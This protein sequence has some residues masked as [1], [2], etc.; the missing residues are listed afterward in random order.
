[1]RYQLIL[2]NCLNVCV[3][4][5][6]SNFCS[7]FQREGPVI[8]LLVDRMDEVIYLICHRFRNPQHFI[9]DAKQLRKAVAENK[10]HLANGLISIGTETSEALQQLDITNNDRQAFLTAVNYV[11]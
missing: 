8:H 7:F 5:V 11:S 1:M 10:C 6:F 4:G 9:K 3:A 2:L